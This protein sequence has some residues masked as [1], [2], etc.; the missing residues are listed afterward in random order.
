[1]Q[2]FYS[3]IYYYYRAY[4]LNK[5][6]FGGDGLIKKLSKCIND[7][8][9]VQYVVNYK[10]I[11]YTSKKH[12]R[13]SIFNYLLYCMVV[14]TDSIDYAEKVLLQSPNWK[15]FSITEFTEDTGILVD[16]LYIKDRLYS[17]E[18]PSELVWKYLFIVPTATST[19]L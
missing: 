15:E 3:I 13:M 17:T 8:I 18:L 7:C 1:M 12:L 6:R 2:Y 9:I 19:L 4:A 5:Y 11:W 10:F 14:I 16:R